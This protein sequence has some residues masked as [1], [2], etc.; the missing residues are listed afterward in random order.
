MEKENEKRKE[1]QSESKRPI[2]TQVRGYCVGCS[3]ALIWYG[4]ILLGFY[5][6][7][8]PLLPLIFINRRLYRLLTDSLYSSWEAFNVSLLQLVYRVKLVLTGDDLEPNE[9]ALI[10]LNHPTRTDWNFLWQGLFHA[11]PNHNSKIILKE[12]LRKVPGMGWV[13]AMT[14]FIYLKRSWS[15]DKE[16]IDSMLDYLSLIRSEG[17]KQLVLFPEGTNITPKSKLR[18]DD[19]AMKNNK[20]LYNHVIHPRT[21]GFVHLAR[22]MLDRNLLDAVYDVTIAYPGTRPQSE[23]SLLR[24]DL[25]EQVNLHVMRHP[26]SSLPSTFVGM[27]KW[28]EERWRIKEASLS[29]FY[30][31]GMDFPSRGQFQLLPRPSTVLQPL[32]I[33]GCSIFLIWIC[34]LLMTSWWALLWVFSATFAIIIMESVMGGV[35]EME[36]KLEQDERSTAQESEEDFEHLKNE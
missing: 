1:T 2:L 8:A 17:G 32:C 11:S 36:M 30:S 28:L 18:S 12:Q 25:P 5:F 33:T 34:W 4:S 22:G 19:F 10:V 7:Y 26:R 16:V 31:K 9:H 35:Q 3:Y 24:G 14:R 20:P 15:A 29:S 23:A 6:L 13:M 21:T 27:E